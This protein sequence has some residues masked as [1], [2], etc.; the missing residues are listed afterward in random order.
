MSRPTASGSFLKASAFG[1]A[2][3][4]VALLAPAPAAQDPAP[5][6]ELP[7][8]RA[9]ANLVRL[10]AYVTADE[11]PVGDLTAADFEVLED[12][13]P[14]RIETLEV[15]RPRGPAAET[16][17]I[18]PASADEAR[19]MAV[20]PD[21]RLFV[22]FL[23]VWHVH[24]EGSY[25]AQNP[26]TNFLNRVIGQDDMVGVMTPEMSARNLTL[27]RRTTTIE[28]LLRDNWTWGQRQRLTTPDPR[29]REYED[30]YPNGGP[31]GNIAPLMIE[32]RRARK[33]LDAIEDLIVHLEGI[34]DERKF[35]V[36]ISEGWLLPRRNDPLLQYT[37]TK[38][39]PRVDPIGVD[40]TG[41]LTTATR[42]GER[43]VDS[44]DRD[45]IFLATLD[46]EHD[47]RT[48]LARAN[49]ANVSFYTMDPRGLVASD[50]DLSAPRA[51]NISADARRLAERQESLRELAVATDGQALLNTNNLDGALKR[52][53]ADVSLYYLLG[54]YSTNT[55][56]DGGFRRL[57]VRVKRPGVQV[58]ARPGYLAP[59]EAE[60][61]S[62]R[63]DRLMNGAPPGHSDTPPE[64]RR[65]LETITPSR[66][67][68][69]LRVIAVGASGRITLTTELDAGIAKAAEWQQGGTAR[70]LIDHT[71]GATAPIV[72]DVTLKAGQ[73]TFSVE[74]TGGG[75]LPA[76]RY[77]I[78]LSVLAKDA[79]LPLQT[80]V[81]VTVPEA[82]ALLA[83]NGL[84]SR[85][86]PSTGLQYVATAD[87]RFQ[88][89]ERIRFEVPR[90]TT[91]GTVTARLLSRAGQ[92][93]PLTVSLRDRAD[94]A[95]KQRF[96]V[97]DLVLAPLAQ[98]EY[99]LEVAIEKDGKTERAAYGFRVVP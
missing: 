99:V 37:D 77:V 44:C 36:M 71:G 74:E 6:Q 27:A 91:D 95:S 16:A 56:L 35:V 96:V 32:R 21:A 39:I 68:V 4:V 9:G 94:E 30:C 73:R 41:Q 34:R 70:V 57:T 33:T 14:Q 53:M 3:L 7:R 8:F 28:G 58:R 62:A 12:G 15:I 24:I 90:L 80:T 40:P 48:L 75:A 88:R 72:R 42:I 67:I 50:E 79:A 93:L 97:A 10:D 45:R 22:L 85:R 52:M 49:R 5:R 13:R 11:Q 61:A 46:F 83:A 38:R 63:V 23:D 54:Y 65:A 66:G 84:A 20:A 92:P 43:N 47:F 2:A 17:R 1:L 25:R 55:K 60:A 29:E 26:M 81:D 69:P 76:G 64:F 86:G 89:T 31:T 18:E 87:A 19:S 78:R 98:G 51:T 82:G 59:T